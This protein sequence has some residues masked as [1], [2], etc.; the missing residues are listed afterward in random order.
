KQLLDAVD[1]MP[2]T[3]WDG[4]IRTALGRET[5]GAEVPWMRVR[6]NWVH[7]IDL[8]AGARVD[9]LPDGV[10]V[11]LADEVAQVMGAREG[12]P[13]VALEATD[14]SRSWTLGDGAVVVKGTQAALLAW[15]IG[16]SRG[17][18]LQASNGALPP[19]PR[20]L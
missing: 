14:S 6:E 20:W 15:L 16:R 19:A 4:A 10:V 1:A 17:E 3:A 2:D 12:S 13:S 11:A 18:G 7:A 9:Q 5:T 8:A